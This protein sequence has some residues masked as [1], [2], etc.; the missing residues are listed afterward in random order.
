MVSIVE[1]KK[2]T[3][4]CETSASAWA[5]WQRYWAIS[6]SACDSASALASKRSCRRLSLHYIDKSTYNYL[7]KL[8]TVYTGN[9]YVT[10]SLTAS[11]ESFCSYT[12][13]ISDMCTS[14]TFSCNCNTTLETK[15]EFD[16]NAFDDVWFI[17]SSKPPTY[18]HVSIVSSEI[19][20]TKPTM[21]HLRHI[22]WSQT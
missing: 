19:H 16:S 10:W 20:A 9:F 4:F 6:R 15:H 22:L 5:L 17:K 12:S 14:F 18:W 21:E 1:R 8:H 13:M 11:A 2:K 3:S 7:H